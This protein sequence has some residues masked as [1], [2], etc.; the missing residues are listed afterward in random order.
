LFK[1]SLFASYPI[2][3]IL[4]KSMKDTFKSYFW[5]KIRHCPNTGAISRINSPTSAMLW[6]RRFY[7]NIIAEFWGHLLMFV[8]KSRYGKPEPKKAPLS[9]RCKIK[10]RKHFL[11]LKRR[12]LF[13][14]SNIFLLFLFYMKTVAIRRSYQTWSSFLQQ[15]IYKLWTMSTV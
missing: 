5:S 1:T 13:C 2:R 3:N 4:S 7:S 10:K 12:F 6:S 14:S 11:S 8:E 9:I 15:L